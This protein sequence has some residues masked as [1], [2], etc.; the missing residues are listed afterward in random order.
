MNFWDSAKA[1]EPELI[2]TRRQLHRHPEIAF[3]EHWTSAFIADQLEKLGLEVRRNVGRTG[4]LAVLRGAQAG[5]T[6]ALRADIDA[7][8][9]TEE[10]GVDFASEI[11]G[12]MHAC[13][14]DTHITSLLGAARLLTEARAEIKGNVV[15]LFQPAEEL[16]AGAEA[17]LADGAFADPKPDMVF[18]LHNHPEVPI[19]KVAIKSGPLMAASAVFEIRV[20]GKGGHGALPHR[21]IDPIV[22]ASA[23]VMSLQTIASRNVS[24]LEPVVVTVGQFEAGT[25]FNIIPATA[26]LR[27]TFRAFDA[28]LYSDLPKMIDRIAGETAA[29]YGATVETAYECSIAA[30]VVNDE[31]AT[32]II[33]GAVAKALGQ[34]AVVR[35]TPSMGGEDFSIFQKQVP[36]CFV[37]LGVG[38]PE[39]GAIHPWH[40][41][42][43]KVDESALKIG[44]YTLAQAAVDAMAQLSR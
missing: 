21:N 30:P 3:E 34:A 5:P 39:I 7:L 11:P 17:M 20:T 24:P 42:H 12:R 9:V 1:I 41:P 37:W 28:G 27:G 8:P 16:G 6:I 35:P 4:V 2:A 29:A 31:Q 44:A 36:G 10:S 40:S 19:G 13:G 23:I 32:A 26:T 33:E 18:G 15:F 25:A 14:H 22:A 38:N 43:Y